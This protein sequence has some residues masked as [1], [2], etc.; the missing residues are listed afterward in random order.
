MLL[1]KNLIQ[2]LNW[3]YESTGYTSRRQTFRPLES[4]DIEVSL[5]IP[6]IDPATIELESTTE[7]LTVKTGSKTLRSY[8]LADTIDSGSISASAEFG[9]L[10]ILV[11]LKAKETPRKIPVLVS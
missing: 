1:S 8:Q 4:G 6:G 2:T 7:V 10:K 5:E 3:A 11:P 9:I